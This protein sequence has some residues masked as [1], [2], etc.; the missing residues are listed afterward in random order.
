MLPE[1]QEAGEVDM[2]I[3]KEYIQLNGGYWNFMFLICLAMALWISFTTGAAIIMEQWCEDPANLGYY[4]YLYVGLSVG[5]NVFILFRAYKLIMAGAR[6]GEI[7]HRKMMKSLLYA[8]L[9]DFFNRVPVG[10]IVNRLT[11]DLRELDEEIGIKVGNV[12]VTTFRLA[13]NLVICVYG[14]SPWIIIPI[15]IVGFLAHRVR[16]YYMKS[17]I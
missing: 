14:S 3:F 15:F 5:S 4:L 7:V 17:Q 2:K 1:D 9:G 13:G 6:Q 16:T 11:K 10:R 8:S 12:L